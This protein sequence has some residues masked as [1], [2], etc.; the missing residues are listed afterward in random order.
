MS[1]ANNTHT[2]TPW[3]VRV[4]DY[5]ITSGLS[6][7]AHY[8]KVDIYP[9]HLPPDET[10]DL[11]ESLTEAD[12]RFIVDA[13]NERDSLKARVEG[14]ERETKAA[15]ELLTVAGLKEHVAKAVLAE[16]EACAKLAFDLLEHGDISLD[17]AVKAIRERGGQ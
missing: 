16:R 5:P 10:F 12:A 13:V 15:A 3:V 1:D 2:P 11:T 17:D 14:L 4:Y 7:G 8:R 6:A 9:T